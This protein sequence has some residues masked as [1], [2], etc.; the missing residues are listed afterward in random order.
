[1]LRGIYAAASGMA[2]ELEK[3]DIYA[4]NLANANT[5]GFRRAE[6]AQRSFRQDLQAATDSA[7]TDRGGG[8][9]AGQWL[10]LRQGPIRETGGSLDVAL[11]GPGLLVVQTPQGQAYTRA[12]NLTRS[13]QGLLVTAA[14]QPV[15]GQAGPIQLTG[16]QVTITDSGSITVDGR[17]VDRLRVVEPAPG[18]TLRASGGNLLQVSATV[19]AATTQVRQGCLEGANANAVRELGAMTRGMRQYE[20]NAEVLR[21]QDAAVSDLARSLAD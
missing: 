18:A 20:A 8:T 13:P 3:A 14:G 10:D 19:P 1:M 17:P 15:L 16:T 2:T 7:E 9:L 6:V 4:N 11:N 12:G 21:T 5:A